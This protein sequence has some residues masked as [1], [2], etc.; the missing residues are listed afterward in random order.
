M[1]NSDLKIT[2][3]GEEGPRPGNGRKALSRFGHLPAKRE[4]VLNQE[5]FHTML[6][7]ER[8]RAERSRQ[9][10]VLMLLDSHSIHRN[11]NATTFTDQLTSVVSDATRE[12]DIIGWYEDSAILAVI[13]TEINVTGSNP[14]TEVLHSKVVT[15]LRD[16]LD[17]KIASKLVITVHVFPESWDKNRPDRATDLKLY[18]DL[19]QKTPRK[20]VPIVVKRGMDIVGSGL[21]LLIL[22]PMLAAI[23]LL[24][25]LTSKGPVIF[26]QERLGEFGKRFKCLKFRTMYANNDSRVHRDFVHRF[27]AGKTREQEKDEAEPAV[28]KITNDPRVTPLGNFLRKTSLDEFPQFWNVLRGEMSLVGPRP[29]I[30]YEFEVYDFWH[31]R[32]VLELKPGVTGL[33]QVSGRSRTCFDDMVR[34][35]LRYSQ[36][37]SLWLDLRILLA[38]PR[39]VFTGDGAF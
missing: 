4:G 18:P 33:W 27:I 35:D 2:A 32:R 9:P 29:P 11:G 6:T 28:F 24:I 7:L 34:L 37:W 31:R 14:I 8:R 12:T 15:A 16:N 25:K 13:F 39:A 3:L 30:P 23:A 20:R 38:T 22:S 19:S 26:E 21:L 5:T 36:R 1:G 17:H 10:F